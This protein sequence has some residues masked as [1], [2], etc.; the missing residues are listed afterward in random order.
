MCHP[1]VGPD[2][3]SILL[4]G[5]LR[6]GSGRGWRG[7][8]GALSSAIPRKLQPLD[9]G[10]PLVPFPFSAAW[11]AGRRGRCPSRKSHSQK[12]K[13]S[14][15]FLAGQGLAAPGRVVG[16]LSAAWGLS[17]MRGRNPGNTH[18]SCSHSST[19]SSLWK[20]HLHQ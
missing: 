14:P 10:L 4:G 13:P 18:S 3:N 19:I 8:P 12:G 2:P 5:F 7:G 16:F 17:S 20:N 9:T 6:P 11:S 15:R 1:F